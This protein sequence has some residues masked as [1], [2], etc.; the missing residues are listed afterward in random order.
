MT[1]FQSLIQPGCMEDKTMDL[2]ERVVAVRLFIFSGRP[3][4]EWVLDDGIVTELASRVRQIIA[5]ERTQPPP[6]GG[7]GYRGFL[8][9]NRA[10][11]PSLPAEFTVFR[12]V[13]IEQPGPRAIP[14]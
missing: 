5:G 7:L 4:P 6:P 8:V 13:L 10:G 9:R 12:G 1:R 2:Q 14:S 3:D 11:N